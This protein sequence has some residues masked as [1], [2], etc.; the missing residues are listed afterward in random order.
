MIKLGPKNEHIPCTCKIRGCLIGGF[1]LLFLKQYDFFFSKIEI[2]T[3]FHIIIFIFMCLFPTFKN[4]FQ[5]T[6]NKK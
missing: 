5:N 3:S 4:N 2:K 6:I 1:L